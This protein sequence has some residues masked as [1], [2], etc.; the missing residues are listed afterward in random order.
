MPS[1]DSLFGTEASPVKRGTIPPEDRRK[2]TE[3]LKAFASSPRMKDDALAL[4][5]NAQARRSPVSHKQQLS[6][7]AEVS[8]ECVFASSFAWLWRHVPDSFF[9][10]HG[11]T[12]ILN[13]VL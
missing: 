6:M 3:R 2:I 4:Y 12:A 7:P 10:T 8:C 9:S 5:V 13:G 1:Y 11:M